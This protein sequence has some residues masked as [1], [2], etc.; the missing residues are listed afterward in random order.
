MKSDELIKEKIRFK[1]AQEVPFVYVEA[2]GLPG[3]MA[4][5]VDEI[6]EETTLPSQPERPR[7]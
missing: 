3:L 6:T 4:I 1:C 7:D 5:P 2:K